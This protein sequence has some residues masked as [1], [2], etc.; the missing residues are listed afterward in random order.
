M[1]FIGYM[2]GTAMAVKPFVLIVADHDKKE[3]CIEG[4]MTNDDPW[5]EQVVK[6]QRS[7]RE[8]NCS[9]PGDDARADAK[10]AAAGYAR[11]FGYKEVPAGSIVEPPAA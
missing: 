8:V 6:A 2:R 5:N 9:T 10:K 3:F 7:G 4:P 1:F 11:E